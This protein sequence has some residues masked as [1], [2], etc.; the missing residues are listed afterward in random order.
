MIHVE[1]V[2]FTGDHGK[3]INQTTPCNLNAFV[4]EYVEFLDT[5]YVC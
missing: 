4:V 5:F 1:S 2:I 3:L